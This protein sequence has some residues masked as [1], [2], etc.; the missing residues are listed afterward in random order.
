MAFIDEAKIKVMAGGGGNGAVAFHREPFKPKGGPDGGDGGDGG[1]VILRADGSVG[2]LL[3]VK[4]HP[5]IKAERGAHGEGGRRQ[6]SRGKDRVVLVPPGTVLYDDAGVMLADLASAG[7]SVVAARGGRGGRGN[8]RFATATRRAP[9]FSEKGEPGEE[10][11]LKLEL[12][13]L[14]DV[15]LVGFPNAG[16]ST[17]I[18]RIS[19]A[20]PKIADYPFTTLSP[21]L[22]VVKHGDSS[23]V[24]ADIPGLVPG[25]SEG[26]GLGHRFL[27]HVSRAAVLLFLVDPTAQDRDPVEDVPVLEEELRAFAAELAERPSLVALTKADASADLLPR[28]QERYP[29][30]LVISAVSGQGIDTL[31][32]TLAAEVKRVRETTPATVGYVRHVVQEAPISVT[33]VHDHWLVTGH[34]PE[35][36]VATTDMDNAEAV[37]RLQRR[38]ISMGVERSLERAGARRGDEVRI[39]D[40][41][42]D[43]EPEGSAPEDEEDADAEA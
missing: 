2:T 27:R 32:R 31:V 37:E 18:S 19:A 34:R 13:L 7:D 39:S 26:K 38:L 33:R 40:I 10:R 25:A 4:E 6:G 15:G 35:R 29:D 5:H 42:F 41:A 14:A 24:V 12:R 43:F 23:F 11:W 28:L 8:A 1:S 9:G 22:G 30:A 20:K 17:L 36:A 16:K 21:N 3:D